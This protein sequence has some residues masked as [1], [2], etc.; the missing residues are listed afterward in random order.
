MKELDGIVQS[1]KDTIDELMAAKTYKDV[2]SIY[3]TLDQGLQRLYSARYQET[4]MA[5]RKEGAA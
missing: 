5:S 4:W 2:D 1:L 3:S